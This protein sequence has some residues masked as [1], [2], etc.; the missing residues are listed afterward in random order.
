MSAANPEYRGNNRVVGQSVE[1]ALDQTIHPAYLRDGL[2]IDIWHEG[3]RCIPTQH[4]WKPVASR[5]DYAGVLP[6]GR[7][8][9]FDAKHCAERR[10]RHNKKRLH[11][12]SDLWKVHIAGG[13]AGILVVNWE[14]ERGWWLLPQTEWMHQEFTST[15]LE[16]GEAVVEVGKLDGWGWLPDWLTTARQAEGIIR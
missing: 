8:V 6:G 16:P 1:N 12:L 2:L 9:C 11:Q 10:Y 3:T 13:L 5:P 15:I 4:G 7:A 14:L